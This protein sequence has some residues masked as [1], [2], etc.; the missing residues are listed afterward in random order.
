MRTAEQTQEQQQAEQG[1]AE[2]E[3]LP[4][5]LLTESE[6]GWLKVLNG[7]DR[8]HSCSRLSSGG[9]SWSMCLLT[10]SRVSREGKR[11][12]Q[13]GGLQQQVQAP[14]LQGAQLEGQKLQAHQELA[15]QQGEK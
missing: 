9:L 10:S 7:R 14:Q 8:L 15:S 6:K 1:L 11:C 12:W 13:G 2:L 5:G 4:D 3:W